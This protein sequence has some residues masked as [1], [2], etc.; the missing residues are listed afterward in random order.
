MLPPHQ[1]APLHRPLRSLDAAPGR[2]S[3]SLFRMEVME[4]GNLLDRVSILLQR[5]S[6]YYEQNQSV[7]QEAICS[8]IAGGALDFPHHASFA[9]VKMVTWWEQQYIS[10]FGVPSGLIHG[11]EGEAVAGGNPEEFVSTVTSCCNQLMSH[12]HNLSQEALDHADLQVL[13][14]TLGAAALVANALW[15]YNHAKKLPEGMTFANC[16]KEYQG[17]K[18]AL[19]ERV[20]D[21][22]CRLTS[23]YVLQDADCL[24]WEA[25]HAFFESE[26]GSFVVQMWWL[27]M[28]GTRQ[29][30]WSTLPP[31]TAQR[32]FA[33]MLSESLTIFTARY[34]QVKFKK[35]IFGRF[36]RC[37]FQAE[38][39]MA[40]LP[41]IANDICNILRCV[42]DLLPALCSC[43]KELTGEKTVSQVVQ[44]LH[45]KCHILLTCL[46]FRGAP[47][48]TLHKIFFRG[49]EK[50]ECF[51]QVPK[52][53]VSPWFAFVTDD[54]D[55]GTKSVF[56]LTPSSAILLELNILKFQPNMSW[57]LL[58]KLVMMR[59]CWVAFR[60]MKHVF[61]HSCFVGTN[62]GEPKC[63]GFMCNG[64]CYLPLSSVEQAVVHVVVSVGCEKDIRNTLI[65][66]LE[67]MD[68]SWADCLDKTQVWNQKRPGWLEALTAP[69][70]DFLDPI[71]GIINKAIS[72]KATT[73]QLLA[74][75]IALLAQ[76]VDCLPPGITLTTDLLQGILPADC[77][78]I[79]GLVLLQLLFASLYSRVIDTPLA[80]S[81]CHLIEEDLV[82]L[83][84]KA[85]CLNNLPRPSHDLEYSHQLCELQ[86]SQLLLTKTGRLSLKVLFEYLTKENWILTALKQEIPHP[87]SNTLLFTMFHI[88]QHAFDEVLQGI[89]T[90]DWDALLNIP[91]GIDPHF[92]WEQISARLPH[93]ERDAINKHDMA[94]VETLTKVFAD[95]EEE[96]S[97]SDCG[98]LEEV[99][100][101]A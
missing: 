54:I 29:D 53:D 3:T 32:V 7:L 10:V 27:Y 21:L 48:S 79:G 80:E 30:L 36:T 86:V 71:I 72:E 44:H 46:L 83:V 38:T 61:S 69:L 58:L 62:E 75:S 63:T 74:L 85:S 51:K 67:R 39:S 14:S 68:T 94:V 6:A 31:K 15:V 56:E 45:D 28:Q 23:L 16:L 87:N 12:L 66:L 89:W 20:L 92:A 26:R 40:R 78:P 82:D 60:L 17:M 37:I 88:G 90:P 81:I 65:H 84:G 25:K 13:T 42:A 98:Q 2:A 101:L 47:L 97:E 34:C 24:N 91:L 95:V 70:M 41:L 35:C 4:E 50:V 1:I 77:S 22:H 55:Y 33:G 19:A 64:D 73:E 100:N 93:P 9:S 8:G 59:N 99:E 11:L 18:E 43:A 49:L 76:S 96:G 57:P 52:G 5:D